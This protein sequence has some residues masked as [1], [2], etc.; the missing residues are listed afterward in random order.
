M[1]LYDTENSMGYWNIQHK[2]CPA[3]ISRKEN[4]GGFKENETTNDIPVEYSTRTS[5]NSHFQLTLLDSPSADPQLY[6]TA[7]Q[8]HFEFTTTMNLTT[9]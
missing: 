6:V 8:E 4:V 2:K 1:P 7:F 9:T 3:G 5:Q